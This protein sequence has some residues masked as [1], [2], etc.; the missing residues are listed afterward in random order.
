MKA[1]ELYQ[2]I[3]KYA[4]QVAELCEDTR[5]ADL[6]SSRRRSSRTCARRSPPRISPSPTC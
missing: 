4:A 6:R 1:A 3:T 5:I 2:P